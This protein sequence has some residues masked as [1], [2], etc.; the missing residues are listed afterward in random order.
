ML[1]HHFVCGAGCGVVSCRVCVLNELLVPILI[2]K[3]GSSLHDKMCLAKGT[4]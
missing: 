2:F 4:S 1:Y 3:G